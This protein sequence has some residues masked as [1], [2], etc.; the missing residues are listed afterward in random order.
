VC[1]T[2]CKVQVW[3]TKQRKK[4]R[5]TK[6]YLVILK[7]VN[8][9][10]YVHQN[11]NTY[12]YYRSNNRSAPSGSFF[13]FLKLQLPPIRYSD[14]NSRDTNG[15]ALRR[16]LRARTISCY[17]EATSHHS[18]TDLKRLFKPRTETRDAIQVRSPQK[19]KLQQLYLLLNRLPL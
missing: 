1:M 8:V 5:R 3:V 18:G 16:S 4:R 17:E 10:L 14:S 19:L 7:M 6:G 15:A 12:R 9:N 13:S 2:G 11:D